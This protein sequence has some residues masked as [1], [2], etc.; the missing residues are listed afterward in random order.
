MGSGSETADDGVRSIIVSVCL[1][2]LENLNF[3]LVN[4]YTNKPSLSAKTHL[5]HS[6]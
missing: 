2:I 3:T 4:D 6:L 1:L 5:M